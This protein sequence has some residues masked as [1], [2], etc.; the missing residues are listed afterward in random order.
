MALQ[1]NLKAKNSNGDHK[2]IFDYE[3]EEINATLT[4]EYKGENIQID[5]DP[6]GEDELDDLIGYLSIKKSHIKSRRKRK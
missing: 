1:L 3:N 6:I 5:F 2:L 4:G